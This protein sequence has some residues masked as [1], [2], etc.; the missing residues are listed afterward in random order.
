MFINE[1]QAKKSIKLNF[2]S[3]YVQIAQKNLKHKIN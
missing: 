2:I 1:E 3:I